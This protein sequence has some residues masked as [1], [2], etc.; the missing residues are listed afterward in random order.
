MLVG[1]SRWHWASRQGAELRCWHDAPPARAP[2]EGWSDLERWAAVG[3]VP[4]ELALPTERCLQLAQVPLQ[5][6][7][8]W[9]GIDRALAAWQ[10]W[11]EHGAAH[12]VMVAD[13]GTALSITCVDQDGCFPVWVCN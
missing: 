13:A 2:R 11:R 4:Q 6:A 1:N 12:N 7:P 3:A 8:S 10:A 9:L 5:A